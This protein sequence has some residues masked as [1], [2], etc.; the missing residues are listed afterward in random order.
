MA[1]VG[2][3]HPSDVSYFQEWVD[4]HLALGFD[5]V[6]LY[7]NSAD[8]TY[9]RFS[10]NPRVRVRH[11]PGAQMQLN[12][13]NDFLRNPEH[14][15]QFA[16]FFDLDEFLVLRNGWT[17][18][19]LMHVIPENGALGVHWVLFG[20][21]GHSV[22]LPGDVRSRFTRRASQVDPHYKSIVRIGAA[23]TFA[24]PHRPA[25]C[26]VRNTRG[27]AIAT[28]APPP[29]DVAVLFH[30]FTKS[31]EEFEAK[32]M[33]GRADVSTVRD[34]SDFQRHDLNDVEDFSALA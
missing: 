16:A 23:D 34:V 3:A 12:A 19:R 10:E 17:L 28:V 5:I 11:M 20:S 8:Q 27:E 18:R 15:V 22:R 14:G 26:L 9:A 31:R 1:L 33:R 24:D 30:Y 21:N 25:K 13:Y 6:C 2:I 29:G 4:H 7:D 32:R